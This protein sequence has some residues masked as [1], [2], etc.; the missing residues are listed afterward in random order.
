[1]YCALTKI[2][3]FQKDIYFKYGTTIILAKIVDLRRMPA[4]LT[5]ETF[6]VSFLVYSW[7]PSMAV[8]ASH[9]EG[10]NLLLLNYIL[11]LVLIQPGY[12][13]E[14]CPSAKLV[15]VS[16]S[17]NFVTK[18]NTNLFSSMIK[19]NHEN[20]NME[21]QKI[22]FYSSQVKI[23]LSNLNLLIFHCQLFLT[24]NMFSCIFYCIEQHLK[25]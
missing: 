18:L 5:R 16:G 25:L 24:W 13:I 14:H 9:P 4:Q 6:L 8:M 15:E 19:E 11:I 2:D 23:I 1:M 20:C 7:A 3:K 17:F 22:T 12:L 10:P 21:G